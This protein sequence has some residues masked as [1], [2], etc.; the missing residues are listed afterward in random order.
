MFYWTSQI[1]AFGQRSVVLVSTRLQYKLS[2]TILS[3]L[4]A[5]NFVRGI[6]VP[7]KPQCYSK[8]YTK[9]YSERAQG[10]INVQFTFKDD[11]FLTKVEDIFNQCHQI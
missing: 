10:L 6:L 3:F 5:S 2:Y 1:A 8:L 7:H 11:T 4:P 9:V